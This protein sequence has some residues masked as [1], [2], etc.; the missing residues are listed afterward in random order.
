MIYSSIILSDGY[1][2]NIDLQTMK[3]DSEGY[4]WNNSV[5]ELP[6]TKFLKGIIWFHLGAYQYRKT[7]FNEYYRRW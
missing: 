7:L 5:F 6:E 1:K 4:D 2:V 3:S